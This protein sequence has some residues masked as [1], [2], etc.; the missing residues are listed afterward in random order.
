MPNIAMDNDHLQRIFPLQVVIFRSHV[1]HYQRVKKLGGATSMAMGPTPSSSKLS[2]HLEMQPGSSG[3][4]QQLGLALGMENFQ[5]TMIDPRIGQRML[6]V[7]RTVEKDHHFGGTRVKTT[8]LNSH[9]K[10]EEVDIDLCVIRGRRIINQDDRIQEFPPFFTSSFWVWTITKYWWFTHRTSHGKLL[11]GG[12]G[13][14]THR[15]GLLP[16][17]SEFLPRCLVERYNIVSCYQ[18]A[19]PPDILA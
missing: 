16:L 13:G 6:H 8:F 18:V 10:T 15:L 5:W 17:C 1:S 19:G 9:W 12:C 4:Y 14:G 3:W 11:V 2:S 7:F